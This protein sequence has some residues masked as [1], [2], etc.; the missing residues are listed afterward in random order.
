[1]DVAAINST[2]ANWATY[3]AEDSIVQIDSGV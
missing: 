2:C 1:M 3:V